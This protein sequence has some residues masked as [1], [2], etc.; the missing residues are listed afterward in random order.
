KNSLISFSE[1]A[2]PK[3][4]ISVSSP[5]FSLILIRVSSFTVTK[6]VCMPSFLSQSLINPPVNP[7][8]NPVARLGTFN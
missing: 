7:P 4:L 6:P 8:K 3:P 5:C 1:I 2:G